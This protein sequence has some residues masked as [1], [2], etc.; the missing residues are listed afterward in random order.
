[1]YTRFMHQQNPSLKCI[2][3][4]PQLAKVIIIV[5]KFTYTLIIAGLLGI[6]MQNALQVS[7]SYTKK[8]LILL[9]DGCF[10]CHCMVATVLPVDS[11]CP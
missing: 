4:D 5:N 7:F 11:L 2:N 6:P 1:M 3:F 9:P 8:T 10:Y